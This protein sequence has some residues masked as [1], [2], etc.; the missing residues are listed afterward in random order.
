MAVMANVN[1]PKKINEVD[2]KATPKPVDESVVSLENEVKRARARRELVQENKLTESLENPPTPQEPAFKVT[3]GVNIGNIDLQEQQ[4][5]QREENEKVRRESQARIEKL[6]KDAADAREA[7]NKANLD[8]MQQTLGGQLLELKQAIAGGNRHNI[9][10]ELTAVETLATKLGFSKTPPPA[11]TFDTSSF[12]A[13]IELKRLEQE[14]QRENRRFQLEMKRDDRMWQLEL[15]KLDAARA[16]SAAKLEAE[17]RRWET[18]AA[19]PEQLGGAVAQGLISRNAAGKAEQ[20]VAAQAE[21]P[22]ISVGAEPDAAAQFEC[23]ACH[24]I[25][26]LGPT[27][28][29]AVCARC[30]QKFVIHRQP[31][32]ESVKKAAPQKP[33]PAPAPAPV[34]PPETPEALTN[35][36]EEAEF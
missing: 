31:A 9:M 6:E 3:G 10:E 11:T 30:G 8:H 17:K 35:T 25:V 2:P 1:D 33:A 14:M 15:A 34:P 4:R 19:I 26:G 13:Q 32:P 29:T 27:S 36:N 12:H 7:L 21:E 22:P 24:S 20:K 28:K 5:L 23:P 16:E 18:I